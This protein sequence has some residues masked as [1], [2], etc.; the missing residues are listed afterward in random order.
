MEKKRKK[1]KKKLLL[2]KDSF[3]IDQFGVIINEQTQSPPF[4][5]WKKDVEKTTVS[6]PVE[7]SSIL[8]PI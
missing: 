8:P 4:L 2:T 6:P 7:N 1:K 3:E 5:F